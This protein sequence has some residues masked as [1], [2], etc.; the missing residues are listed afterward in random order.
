MSEQVGD[1]IQQ[2]NER[3]KAFTGEGMDAYDAVE[4]A[5]SEFKLTVL[6]EG[7]SCRIYETPDGMLVNCWLD[8]FVEGP[9]KKESPFDNQVGWYTKK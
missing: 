7:E 2:L 6:S 1:V 3:V 5:A 9:G 4:Q 8:R